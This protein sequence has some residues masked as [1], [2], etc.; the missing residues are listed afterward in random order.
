MTQAATTLYN[1]AFATDTAEK[2]TREFVETK[3][4]KKDT[5][6]VINTVSWTTIGIIANSEE[7]KEKTEEE[8]HKKD[9]EGEQKL[10]SLYFQEKAIDSP[11]NR[12]ECLHNQKRIFSYKW[13]EDIFFISLRNWIIS[14]IKEHYTIDNLDTKDELIFV[15]DNYNFIVIQNNKEVESFDGKNITSVKNWD[16]NF[17][18][19]FINNSWE[20]KQ[21][22]IGQEKLQTKSSLYS[23]DWEVYI[24]SRDKVFIN[25]DQEWNWQKLLSD[26]SFGDFIE[27]IYI[28]SVNDS[29]WEKLLYYNFEKRDYIPLDKNFTIEETSIG[30]NILYKGE[31]IW[32]AFKKEYGN[33]KNTNDLLNGLS[34]KQSF[35]QKLANF[36]L[37][38]T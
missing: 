24:S 32:V 17:T 3:V 4:W 36:L 26:Y 23:H 31:K 12:I 16:W 6:A 2:L 35:L 19:F 29:K 5:E 22:M 27:E 30:K 8:K 33:F 34:K 13:K 20:M 25:R 7:T 9:L 11:Y 37:K 18:H 15:K 14:E 1:Q 21:I 10:L 28:I 38:K